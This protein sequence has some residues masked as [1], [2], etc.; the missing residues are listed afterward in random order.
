VRDIAGSRYTIPISTNALARAFERPRSRVQPAGCA[1]QHTNR[2]NR[3]DPGS[4]RDVPLNEGDRI[5]AI[6][7]PVHREPAEDPR[8]GTEPE[9]HAGMMV[10]H[11]VE[12][13]R[14]ERLKSVSEWLKSQKDFCFLRPLPTILEFFQFSIQ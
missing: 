2:H 14:E 1:F 3:T 9:G 4:A 5:P 6:L 13:W 12:V 8:R 11:S 10:G 7:L